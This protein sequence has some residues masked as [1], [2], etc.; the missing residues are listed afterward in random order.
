MAAGEL[1][2]QQR[3]GACVDQQLCVDR[4]GRH[5]TVWPAERVHRRSGEGVLAP[6]AGVVHEDCHG[7]EGILRLIEEAGRAGRVGEIRFDGQRIAACGSDRVANNRRVLATVLSVGGRSAWV[8]VG[9]AQAEVGDHHVGAESGEREGRRRSDTVV[10]PGHQGNALLKR[11]DWHGMIS[12]TRYVRMTNGSQMPA[13][14]TTL[15]LDLRT[16]LVRALVM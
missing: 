9:D 4:L 16:S 3:A 5:R 8:I 6:A 2:D 11:T 10:G 1:G 7:S 13:T 15:S 14:T 12:S